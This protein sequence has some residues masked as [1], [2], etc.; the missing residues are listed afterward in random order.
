MRFCLNE[1]MSKTSD[2]SLVMTQTKALFKTQR[3]IKTCLESL[4]ERPR[5]TE[6]ITVPPYNLAHRWN[7]QQP[8]LVKDDKPRELGAEFW[9]YSWVKGLQEERS[10][11]QKRENQAQLDLVMQLWRQADMLS[12]AVLPY[13]EVCPIC[14]SQ[15]M[16]QT[17]G[18]IYLHLQSKEHQ[19]KEKEALGFLDDCST[20]TAS[21]SASNY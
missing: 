6:E 3:T 4:L 13:H 15:V 12:E 19:V 1:M 8:G 10:R 5:R 17:K 14:P 7:I 21:T 20:V 11:E 2:G 16:L 18:Q 9:V